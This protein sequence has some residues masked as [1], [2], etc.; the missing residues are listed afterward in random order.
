[1]L[2]FEVEAVAFDEE[3]LVHDIVFEVDQTELFLFV[4]VELL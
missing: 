2:V 4:G 3:S 1:L